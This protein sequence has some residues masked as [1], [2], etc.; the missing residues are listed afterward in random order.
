MVGSLIGITGTVIRT[1]AVKM[2]EWLKIYE[3]S[4]CRH[5]FPV[6]ADLETRNTFP[7]II[8]CPNQNKVPPCPGK[9]FIALENGSTEARDY[10]GLF[11]ISFFFLNFLKRN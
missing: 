7:K 1:G 3:C 2:L 5:S 11:I 4:S 6:M 10:Q 8:K 9:N